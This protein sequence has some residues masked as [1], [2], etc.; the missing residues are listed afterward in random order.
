M[1]KSI[2]IHLY[3]QA[4]KLLLVNKHNQVPTMI[5]NTYVMNQLP[6]WQQ[7]H[8]NQRWQLNITRKLQLKIY[9][10]QTE[11]DEIRPYHEVGPGTTG[12]E[13]I[14]LREAGVRHHG[15]DHSTPRH[16][17]QYVEMNMSQLAGTCNSSRRSP[18]HEGSSSVSTKDW[19]SLGK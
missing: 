5:T 14:N 9:Q 6:P 8:P 16:V 19:E 4:S 3:L 2:F 17:Y 1:H 10:W 12:G 18:A 15:I 7:L 13:A 11:Y